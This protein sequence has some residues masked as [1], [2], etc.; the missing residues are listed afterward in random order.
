MKKYHLEG[1]PSVYGSAEE[2]TDSQ[3]RKGDYNGF[4]VDELSLELLPKV[5]QKG[6]KYGVIRWKSHYNDED[7]RKIMLENKTVKF[8]GETPE[9]IERGLDAIFS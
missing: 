8:G 1:L 4:L 6:N 3:L 5:K 7:L 2:I 9:D